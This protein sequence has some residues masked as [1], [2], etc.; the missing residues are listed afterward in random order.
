L[1]DVRESL[2]PA[3]VRA[4]FRLAGELRELGHDPAAWRQHLLEVLTG[5][6]GARAAVIGE[7]TRIEHDDSVVRCADAVR[8]LMVCD[9]GVDP[10]GRAGFYADVVWT[11]HERDPVLDAMLPLYGT[12]FTVGRREL[13]DGRRWYRSGLAERFRAHACDDFIFSMQPVSA[14]GC[15]SSLELWRAWGEPGFGMRERVLV[16]LL[17]EELARDWHVPAGQARLTPRQRQVLECLLAGQSE[18]EL[19][20][21]LGLSTHTAHDHVKAIHRALGVRSRGE[22]LAQARPARRLRLVAEG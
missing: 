3:D 2:D 21:A 12:S 1:E 22:L 20:H 8:P 10:G 17:H 11:D 16:Q 18:K 9:R 13:V 19:A 7:L 5:L 6:C 14:L 15:I 4:L